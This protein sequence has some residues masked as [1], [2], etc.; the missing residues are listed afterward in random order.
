MEIYEEITNVT[1]NKA[2]HCE[3]KAIRCLIANYF[4]GIKMFSVIAYLT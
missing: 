1:K 3:F 2:L 4:D